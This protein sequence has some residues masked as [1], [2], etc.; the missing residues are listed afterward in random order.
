[1]LNIEKR[2]EDLPWL[3]SIKGQ[4][5]EQIAAD[6]LPHALLLYG[7]AG[8]GRR[9][10][11]LWLVEQL[12]QARLE[13]SAAPEN[14]I[15]QQ[16]PDVLVLEPPEGKFIIPVNTIRDSLTPF[17]SLTSHGAGHRVAIIYPAEGL[18]QSAANALLK[19]L[20][21][22][23]PGCLVVL[24]ALQPGRLPATVRSR[25][26]L[27]H[28]PPPSRAAALDW[29]AAQNPEKDFAGLLELSGNAPLAALELEASGAAEFANRLLQQVLRLERGQTDPVS[30]AAVAAKQPGLALDLLEWRVAE[31]VRSSLNAGEKAASRGRFRKMDQIRELRRVIN[32]GIKAELSLAGLLLDW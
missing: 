15:T 10:L 5:A 9:E 24:V 1:M 2:F 23:P 3:E 27:L 29:L 32:G 20:E 28:V 25:C 12:L 13:V 21:E 19:T 17:L 26:Q 6:Q 30:V 22:P 8:T 7:L 18:A 4:L 16:R 14:G 31:Q 11:A